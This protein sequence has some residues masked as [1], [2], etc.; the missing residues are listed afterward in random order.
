[1]LIFICLNMFIFF[2]KNGDF[3]L[4]LDF[5]IWRVG[6]FSVRRWRLLGISI[7]G[8]WWGQVLQHIPIKILLHTWQWM[9]V[10]SPRSLPEHCLQT[11]PGVQEYW[12]HHWAVC[13]VQTSGILWGPSCSQERWASDMWLQELHLPLHHLLQDRAGSA[14]GVCA[15]R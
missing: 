2:S 6:R 1:M 4:V 5:T 11:L 12:E 13:Q 7:S 14:P 9:S 10:P 3:Q 8:I 15:E